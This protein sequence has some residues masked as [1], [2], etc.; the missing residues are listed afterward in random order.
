M[1][2]WL[3]FNEVDSK[4]VLTHRKIN[5]HFALKQNRFI[6]RLR[7]NTKRS[8]FILDEVRVKIS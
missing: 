2:F 5:T 6:F 8:G 7:N 3:K 4:N 1:L